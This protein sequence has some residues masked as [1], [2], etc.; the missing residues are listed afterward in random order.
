MIVVTSM[1]AFLAEHDKSL[2]LL[3]TDGTLH[4]GF[5]S[6]NILLRTTA[7]VK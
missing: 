7:L 6:L 2:Y 4:E 1:M 5:L 3:I